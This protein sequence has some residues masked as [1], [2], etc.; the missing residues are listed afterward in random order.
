MIK[1]LP[2]K[3]YAALCLWAALFP[4]YAVAGFYLAEHNHALWLASGAAAALLGALTMLVKGKW[5]IPWALAAAVGLALAFP[6]AMIPGHLV[7]LGLML[8]A[9]PRVPGEEWPQPH[10][11]GALVLGLVVQIWAF[12]QTQGDV[13]GATETARWLKIAF[14]VF[15]GF[16]V[17]NLNRVSLMDGITRHTRE[18]PPRTVRV[19]NLWLSLLSLALLYIAASWQTLAA[20]VSRALSA[21]ARFV[22]AVL[23]WI[24]QWFRLADVREGGAG[25]GGGEMGALPPGESAPFWD[26]LEVIAR[27]VTIAA[28]VVLILYLLYRAGKRFRWV[29]AWIRNKLRS[30]ASALGENYVSRT[31]SIFNWEEVADSAAQRL[32]RMRMFR[33]RQPRWDE[34]DNRQRVRR[35]YKT[36]LEKHPDV[37]PSVTARQALTR[38]VVIAKDADGEALADAYDAARYSDQPVS[39]E[40]AEAMR[41]A[42]HLRG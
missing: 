19:R 40:Q 11:L 37:P 5:R 39:P 6:L 24:S 41:K 12:F 36:L 42:A 31:E 28:L 1:R 13:A 14:A 38:H 22:G 20:W 17:I 32:R 3:L 2:A 16:F 10:W 21:A 29:L 25:G 15:V 23:A 4:V 27:A 33:K 9:T 35:G 7:T 30:T 18:K 8:Y 34:L 26:I